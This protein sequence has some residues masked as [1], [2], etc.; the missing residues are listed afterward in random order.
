MKK[1]VVLSGAGISAESGR[2]TFRDQGGLWQKFSVEDVCTPGGFARNTENALLFY[3]SLRHDV[4]N[5]QPNEAHKILAELE[6]DFDVEVITQNVDN[7]H[8]RAGSTKVL[9]LHGEITKSCNLDKTVVEDT[10][11]R[12]INMGDEI[13]G[14]QARPFIVFFEESV[15]M[16]DPAIELT[17]QADIFVVVGTSL[18]VYPAAG[19]LNYVPKTTP[20]YLI[21]PNEVNSYRP[22]TFI[23]DVATKG[24]VKLRELLKN[25]K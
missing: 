23:K 6:K 21:D 17:K 19:L 8:E 5:A 3:N 2:A 7:L 24:M 20:I 4:Q 9:H 13:G 16:L 10:G 18:N 25:E 11:Y 1:L 12:D 22:V 15:P 14:T